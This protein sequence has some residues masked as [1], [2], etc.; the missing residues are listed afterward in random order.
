MKP[1]A[2]KRKDPKPMEASGE[3]KSSGVKIRGMRLD[4]LVLKCTITIESGSPIYLAG[5]LLGYTDEEINL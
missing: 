4:G 3:V 5:R 2:P 1:K